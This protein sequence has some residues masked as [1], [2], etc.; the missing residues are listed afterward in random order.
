MPSACQM[1]QRSSKRRYEEGLHLAQ[2]HWHTTGER[3]KDTDSKASCWPSGQEDPSPPVSSTLS[4]LICTG[5]KSWQS[6]CHRDRAK[7]CF[8]SQGKG[9]AGVFK[10]L[11]VQKPR[12]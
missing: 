12:K 6:Q 8:S 9:K 10:R 11:G 7:R 2:G 4:I 3:N 5:Q 1:L